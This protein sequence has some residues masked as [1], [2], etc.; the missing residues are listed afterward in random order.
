ML[1][2]DLFVLLSAIVF[3]VFVSVLVAMFNKLVDEQIAANEY[4]IKQK[5]RL[6]SL[7]GR[8]FDRSKDVENNE[9]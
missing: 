9:N 4:K 7:D 1:S 3:I 6:K 5:E 2:D 8:V